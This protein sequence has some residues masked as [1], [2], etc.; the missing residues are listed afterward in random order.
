MGRL[1]M[2]GQ[3]YKA[4]CIESQREFNHDLVAAYL[5]IVGTDPGVRFDVGHPQRIVSQDS[6]MSDLSQTSIRC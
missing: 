2:F 6:T 4:S 5:G 3:N 1:R